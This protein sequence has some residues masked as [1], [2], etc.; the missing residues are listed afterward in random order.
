MIHV[1][2]DAKVFGMADFK[3]LLVWQ[4][5]HAL[6]LAVH[7]IA[8]RIRGAEHMSLRSQIIRA[9]ISIPA[10]IV[11][12]RGQ[13]SQRE[14]VRYLRIAVNSTSELEYHLILARDI[15]V[16]RETDFLA[17]LTQLKRVRMMLYGLIGRIG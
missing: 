5:A 17:L 3:K 13:S 16:M 7:P 6:A 14:F 12:G 15:Q 4:K 2:G 8:I 1:A 9:S 10:N 11:E